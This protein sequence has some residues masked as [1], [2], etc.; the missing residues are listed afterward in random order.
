MIE[1]YQ[2]R[3]AMPKGVN[4]LL[5]LAAQ[6]KRTIEQKLLANFAAWGYQE[7]VTPTFEFCET[8]NP[9]NDQKLDEI[10]YKFVDRTGKTLA[11]RHEFTIPIARLTATHYAQSPLPLRF[12][13]LN[14]V[15]R[16]AEPHDGR[17]REFYQA[18]VELLGAKSAAADAEVISVLA[19]SLLALGIADFQI[20]LGHAGFCLGLWDELLPAL[21]AAE[22]QQINLA[23]HHKDA[24]E[25]GRL[26]EAL[27]LAPEQ[28]A[29]F[30]KVTELYGQPQIIN[31]ARELVTNEVSLKALA[32]L[33]EILA[34][35]KTRGL[36]RHIIIDLGEVK[37]IDYYTGMIFEVFVPSLGFPLGSG[38]RYDDLLSEF[39]C[40]LA[41]VGF[42]V[43]LG[44]L[45]LAL[46]QLDGFA[47][48]GATSYLVVNKA[49]GILAEQVAVKLRAAG[50]N[51]VTDLL[52]RE[53]KAVREYSR[54]QNINKIIVVAEKAIFLYNLEDNSKQEITLTELERL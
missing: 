49:D 16:Y 24:E 26:L 50:H 15:Y 42:A 6:K 21:S 53:P 8:L 44:R 10:L 34:I 51:V 38:G 37:E 3:S 28:K 13:Y 9:K 7:V 11:L 27:A 47:P 29:R 39:G 25:L 14:N 1:K 19:T 30:L 35:L 54:S 52:E 5:P 22:Q 23:L 12:S 46:E 36:E 40:P 41:A 31:S 4:L 33:E 48:E 20:N 17:S 2:R 32:E 43:E 45:L 18:G